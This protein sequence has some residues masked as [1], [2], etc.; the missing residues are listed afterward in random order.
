[1]PL[2]AIV[3]KPNVGKSSLFN[4]VVGAR[5]AIES[6]IAG[7]T[8]DRIFATKAGENLTLTFCDTGGLNFEKNG[9]E[10]STEILDSAVAA[11]ETAD[12]IFFCVDAK[13]GATESDREIW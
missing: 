7:T 12:L 1:M 8:R 5:R 10:F 13:N 4:R 11:I 2:I 3:G 9:E 6:E